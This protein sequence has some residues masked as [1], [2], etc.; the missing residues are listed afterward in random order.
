MVCGG[1][2]RS[3]AAH[4]SDL[5]QNMSPLAGLMWQW[6]EKGRSLDVVSTPFMSGTT[7]PQCSKLR[8]NWH[9]SEVSP[10]E[11]LMEQWT[12]TLGWTGKKNVSHDDSVETG[13]GTCTAGTPLCRRL[14]RSCRGRGRVG[15]WSSEVMALH[16]ASRLSWASGGIPSCTVMQWIWLCRQTNSALPSP[17]QTRLHGCCR[18]GEGRRQ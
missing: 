12:R 2:G 3:G 6:E 5:A 16:M 18:E 4:S 7:S 1:R 15:M 9:S 13:K 10:G 8:V 14:A 17:L 11:E